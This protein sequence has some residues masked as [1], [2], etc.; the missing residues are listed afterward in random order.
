MI[1]DT[2]ARLESAVKKIGDADPSRKS[3]LLGL[4]EQ[5]K[6]EARRLEEARAE[7]A[8]QSA[9]DGLTR[10]VR[11]FQSSHPKLV[12]AFDEVCRELSSLG[13]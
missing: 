8:L 4:L 3:E 11:D 5:L 13:I 9:L 6:K 1:K 12:E 7:G 2:L 10:A